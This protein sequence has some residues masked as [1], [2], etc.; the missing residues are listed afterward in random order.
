[1]TTN[2]PVVPADP[3]PANEQGDTGPRTY[4]QEQVDQMLRGS[5]SALKKAQE[6]NATYE[7]AN[8]KR[9][10]DEEAAKAK[11]LEDQGEYKALL[12]QI[13]TENATLKETV[14]K[15]LERETARLET[16]DK[17]NKARLAALPE[18]FHALVPP[19]LDADAAAAQ[20]ARLEPLAGVQAADPINVTSPA[21]RGAPL[22]AKARR[23]LDREE[24]RKAVFGD[25]K[26]TY[27]P[28][29][30]GGDSD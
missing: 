7:A 27:Y 17:S 26:P 20:I 18:Q 3:P 22:D 4:T 23:K 13:R 1:M 6:Q 28:P 30:P 9:A 29:V 16:V 19:G 14:T 12:E 2:N 5:G 10:A 25:K 8:A 11:Q 15:Q 24:A 21:P